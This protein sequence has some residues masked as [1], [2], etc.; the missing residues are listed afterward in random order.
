MRG[1]MDGSIEGVS[2][3]EYCRA[4][5]GRRALPA[6]GRERARCQHRGPG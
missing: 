2:E 6:Y 4:E 5:R 3:S 1:P